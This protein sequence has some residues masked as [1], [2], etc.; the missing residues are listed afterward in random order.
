MSTIEETAVIWVGKHRQA[1]VRP[2]NYKPRRR[3]TRRPWSAGVKMTALGS[4]VFA[5]GVT[6]AVPLA[7]AGIQ[8]F[9]A[10]WWAR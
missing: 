4:V 6:A 1:D 3:R 7:K 2:P 8:L 10:A 9:S 5:I